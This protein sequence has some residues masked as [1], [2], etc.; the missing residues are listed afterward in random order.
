LSH[1]QIATDATKRNRY[2]RAVPKTKAGTHSQYQ[3][4]HWASTTGTGTTQLQA[5]SQARETSTSNST[6][7]TKSVPAN[8]QAQHHRNKSVPVTQQ[9][10]HNRTRSVPA[11]PQAQHKQQVN[12]RK[13]GSKQQQSAITITRTKIRVK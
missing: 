7:E 11:N 5:H 3:W 6:N 9:A 10:Q 13:P 4:Q 8:Q 2:K 12:R 1:I